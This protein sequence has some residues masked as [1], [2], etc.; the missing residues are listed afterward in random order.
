M[1]PILIDE[2]VK[3]QNTSQEFT[4]DID[5][6]PILGWQIAKPLNYDLSL[7]GR[8][9]MSQAILAGKAI[10]VC[11]FED[12][13]LEEQSEYVKRKIEEKQKEKENISSLGEDL[14][15]LGIP[16]V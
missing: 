4:I 5:D 13:T 9:R 2:L 12:L 10:A 15:S 7:V 8:I 14:S 16:K 1:K 3:D 11:F 6:N